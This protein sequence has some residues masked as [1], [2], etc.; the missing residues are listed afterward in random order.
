M[1]KDEILIETKQI[2]D[3]VA[4]IGNTNLFTVPQGY[5]SEV[6][7]QVMSKIH[8]PAAVNTFSQPSPAYFE[9]LAGNILN[10]IKQ[11]EKVSS[12]N[13]VYNEVNELSPLLASIGNRNVYTTPTGY[14][15]TLNITIRATKKTAVVVP[16]QKPVQWFKY[17]VAALVTGIIATS[18]AVFIGNDN[19]GGNITANGAYAAQLSKLSNED[20]DG[21]LNTAPIDVDVPVMSEANVNDGNLTQMFL[22]EV[23]DKDIEQYLNE[24]DELGEKSIKGI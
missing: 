7:D 15:D 5:F 18:A 20:I 22:R 12:L 21:Y 6:A 13:E 4:D 19:K 2:S 3:A 23:S 1:M 24:N 9:G 16:M 8:L 10:R 14:F 17:A 11:T